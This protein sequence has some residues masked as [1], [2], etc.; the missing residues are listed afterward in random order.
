MKAKS[1]PFLRHAALTLLGSIAI[2]SHSAQADSGTWNVDADGLWSLGTNWSGNTIADG[3]GFTASFTND[4]TTDRTVHLD[5]DRTL[6]N[7]AFSDSTTATAGSWILDNN[8]TSTNNLILAGTTPA[9]TV[10]TLGTGKTA[11][12]SAI[13]EGAAGLTKAGTGTL[14]LSGVNTYTGATTLSG[15]TLALTGQNN[16]NGNF[17]ISGSNTTLAFNSGAALGTG[18]LSGTT[19]GNSNFGTGLT[20]QTLGTTPIAINL[21]A[22]TGAFRTASNGDSNIKFTNGT[23]STAAI[24]WNTDFNIYATGNQTITVDNVGGVTFAGKFSTATYGSGTGNAIIKGSQPV[25]ISGT[26]VKTSN[27]TVNLTY[28]GSSTLT[29]SGANSY[30]GTTTIQSGSVVAG[31]NSAVSSSGAFGNANSAIVLGNGSTAASDAPSLL[32]NGGFTVGRAITVGSLTNT[33]AYNA[34]IGSNTTGTA[35]YTGNITLTTTATA[36]TATLQA[37]T[38]GTVE[39]KTGT[40]TPNGKAIAIGSAGNAGTVKLSNNL[41]TAGGVNVNHGT[42]AIN[43][44]TITANLVANTSTF[45][46]GTGSIVGN[47]TINGTINDTLSPG[48]SPGFQS[49]VGN[50]TL[51]STAI[52]N[53]E[54]GG[55]ARGSIAQTGSNYYDAIDV[56]E[57]LILGGTINVSWFNGFSAANGNSFNLLGWSTINATGFNMSTDLS[58]PTLAGGLNWDT[59]SFLTNGTITVIPEPNAAALVGGLCTLLLLRRRRLNWCEMIEDTKLK[60]QPGSVKHP[61]LKRLRRS[62]RRSIQ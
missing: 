48:Y 30:T 28:A 8:G 45:I 16:G 47:S 12:I 57:S 14:V 60:M 46:S 34:T 25:W 1:N 55:T 22:W 20:F 29:L 38:G 53:F 33:N 7:L 32:V 5:S 11:T 52:T 21:T 27:Q 56:T 3:S 17:N 31:A 54:L 18:Q 10:N 4:I 15:G 9:I 36:Y 61:P 2:S 58:L 44:A 6:T 39:F 19:G 37:A 26:V 51:G 35:T 42:L 49:Y 13:I 62:L 24:T 43:G 59:S 50:L 40:W 41:T 23:G